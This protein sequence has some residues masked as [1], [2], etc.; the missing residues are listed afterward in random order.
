MAAAPGER[1]VDIIKR[2]DAQ[3]KPWF[4]L[5]F[6]PPRTSAGVINLQ[7]RIV[8]MSQLQPAF[9]DITWTAGGRSKELTLEMAR[10]C[11]QQG[12]QAQMHISAVGL[13]EAAVRGALDEAKKGGIVNILALRGDLVAQ[14]AGEAKAPAAFPH[15]VDLV[16][17]IR[18]EYGA[19]F[20][21]GVAGYPE[22]HIDG[23]SF[24]AD[25]RH[26]K[27]K[28][29]AGAEYIIT[30][31]FFNVK[32]FTQFL[33][34]CKGM[35]IDCPII[36]G[37]MPI[38]NYESF[39]RIVRFC[40]TDV[41][42]AVT[43]RLEPIRNDDEAVK[44]F[45][46]ALGVEMSKELFAMGCRGV[47]FYTLNLEKCVT[48]VLV[49]CG[50]ARQPSKRVVPWVMART[51][52]GGEEAVRPIYWANRP[53]SYVDRTAHW[54]EFPNGRWGDKR[55]PAFGELSSYHMVKLHTVKPSER[56]AAWGHEVSSE[57]DVAATFV[58]YVRGQ[59]PMLPWC[60]L[61]LANESEWIVDGL[62]L[63]NSSG[64]LTINS[65]P[66][67]DGAPSSDPDVGWGGP[68][69]FVYQKA[70]IEM[71]L[72]PKTLEAFIEAAP[73]YPTLTYQALNAKGESRHNL[74]ADEGGDVS[75][76]VSAVTWGVFPN[77]EV[78]Q[79]TVVDPEAFGQWKDEA[80][81]LWRSQWG[82]LYE[83]GSPSRR[84][85]DSIHDSYFLLNVVDHDFKGGDIL[86]VFKEVA[87]KRQGKA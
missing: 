17:F 22:G 70:Y 24:E 62:V 16:R 20:C 67:V 30:Q 32:L 35:G 33:T 18:R 2:H 85:I 46:S 69:G 25:L 61:A 50:F 72:S 23:E 76:C 21:V 1:V 59:I 42:R 6:F 65:Q 4:S 13:D 10:F 54:D 66:S 48:E 63:L 12:L 9:V 3:G 68:G 14:N 5:E 64:M 41:P 31:Q 87:G 43:D 60:E 79:P 86:A 84:V 52:G 71:F 83:E 73:R 57:A 11:R 75:G 44:R 82:S 27:E 8:R 77:K 40:R 15:A 34:K 36:P 47:H 49:S 39:R 56:R 51:A 7:E 45:G 81:E 37:L 55:S 26:L 74:P 38:H 80:F 78:M 19:A 58:R 29:D 28:V 53:Q